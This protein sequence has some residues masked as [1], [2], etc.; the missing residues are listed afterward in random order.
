VRISS[1]GVTT[2]D[3][4]TTTTR[5]E[6]VSGEHARRGGRAEHHE[7]EFAAL[8]QQ[9]GEQQAL[10]ARDAER[11]RQPVQHASLDGEEGVTRP[12]ISQGPARRRRSRPTCRPR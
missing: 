8:R 4:A 5:I 9:E 7:G 2:I 12:R 6:A 3:S 1:S 10:A 11:S